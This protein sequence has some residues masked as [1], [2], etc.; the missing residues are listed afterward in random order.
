[1]SSS[2]AC[3]NSADRLD[4]SE[5]G[6]VEK[7]VPMLDTASRISVLNRLV[8]RIGGK[9]SFE[10]WWRSAGSGRMIHDSRDAGD[11]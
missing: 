3:L 11:V 5:G 1:M 4:L 9:P 2:I 8:M 7:V 6:F 10:R